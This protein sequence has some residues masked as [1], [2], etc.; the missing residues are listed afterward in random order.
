ML[1]T[2][3]LLHATVQEKLGSLRLIVVSNREPYLHGY[4][5][6]ASL[7]GDTGTSLREAEVLPPIP[8]P[9]EL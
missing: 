7:H 4:V 1:W 8:F 5:A 6:E 9:L 2:D 3:R